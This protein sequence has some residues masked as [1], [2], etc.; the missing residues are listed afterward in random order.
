[1]VMMNYL[2]LERDKPTRLHFTDHLWADR[3]IFD[4]DMGKEKPVRT[5]T[6]W[7][8]EVDASP[9]FKTFSILSPRLADLFAP[10]LH[11]SR[12]RDYDFVITQH[13][14]GFTKT[15]TLEATPRPVHKV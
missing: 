4:K 14:D 15:W 5:L 3:M 13:G 8:D 9:V 7:A 11:D 2:V 12:F 10:Y 6:F 1:M